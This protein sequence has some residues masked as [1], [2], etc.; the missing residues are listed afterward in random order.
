MHFHVPPPDYHLTSALQQRIDEKT[1]PRGSLGRLEDIA[2]QLG[3][4]QQTLT[5]EIVQPHILIFAGDHGAAAEPGLSAFPQD[6]TGQM[7]DNFVNGGAAINVFCRHMALALSVVNAGVKRPLEARPGLIDA[8]IAPGTANYL[9]APAMSQ[10]RVQTALGRGR[11]IA[12]G[13]EAQGCNAVGFGEMGIG[14]TAS[15]SLLTHC[16][17]GAPLMEVTGRGTGLDTA[18]VAHKRALLERAL[19]RGGVPADATGVLAEYGGFEIAM[20]AGAMLGA[21]E[22]RMTLV[23][24]GFI[25]TAALLVAH[26]LA[27]EILHYCLFAHCSDEAGHARQLQHLGVTPLLNLGLRL[28][29]GTG[30]ALAFPLLRAATG[31]LND[32]ASFEA[33][34]VST[35]PGA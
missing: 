14:N 19:A 29:E 17:T 12:H 25:S 15:A 13:L 30:A 16:L 35:P 11:D 1:K 7:V 4:I 8:R 32:M 22:K 5:P 9:H 28:G 21:A 18:G 2:L 34:G 33:A 20:M 10:A 27:P 3:L 31:F 24:D 23:I 6:V 26:R